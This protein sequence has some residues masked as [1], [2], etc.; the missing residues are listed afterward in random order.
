VRSRISSQIARLKKTKT[1]PETLPKTPKSR[2]VSAARCFRKLPLNEAEARAAWMN[3]WS[4]KNRVMAPFQETAL[5]AYQNSEFSLGGIFAP[6]GS[7][8]TL[9]ALAGPLIDWM[10]NPSEGLSILIISPLKSLT[11]DLVRAVEEPINELE[12]DMKVVMRTGDTTQKERRLLK[13]SPPHVLIT[14]PE[15]LSLLLTDPDLRP[16]LTKLRAVIIDEWHELYGTKRGVL[17][18]LTISFLRSLQ[19]TRL[20]TFVLSATLSDPESK[21]IDWAGLSRCPQVISEK[22]ASRPVKIKAILPRSISALPWFGFSGLKLAKEVIHQIEKSETTLLFTNTK[23][24]AERWHQELQ[25]IAPHLIPQ[26]ALHHGS[27]EREERERVEQLLKSGELRV[28]V[29]TSS[30]DLGVDFPKVDQVIQV[31]SVK[32]FSRAHQRAG[33]AFHQPGQSTELSLCPSH[34]F[35]ILEVIALRKGIQAGILEERTQLD[36]PLDVLVQFLLNSAFDRGFRPE[37]MWRLLT[38]TQ[39][40]KTLKRKDFD[41]ALTFLTSGGYSLSAYPEYRKLV[42][43]DGRYYFFHEALASDHKRNMGTI[44]SED[45]IRVQ[46][47]RGSKI[48]QLDEYFITQLN[49]GDQFYFAGQTLELVHIKDMTAYVRRAKTKRASVPV[50]SGSEFSISKALASQMKLV[51]SLLHD[52]FE[53]GESIEENSVLRLIRDRQLSVSRLPRGSEI[54]IE[55]FKS[56]EGHHLLIY[57]LEG[58]LFHQGLGHLLATRLSKI[59]ENSFAVSASDHGIELLSTEPAGAEGDIIASLTDTEGLADEINDSINLNELAK[60]SFREVARVSC[61]ISQGRPHERKSAR[62]LQ[63]SSSLLFDVF[64]KHEPDQPLLLQSFDETRRR[65]M[66]IDL[67]ETRLNEF[68]QKTFVFQDLKDLSPFA[69]P[70]LISRLSS[71]LS[72]EKL[73]TRIERMQKQAVR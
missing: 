58:K 64:L 20:K 7:G 30:L 56:T 28:V 60:R 57:T 45:G 47:Y 41:W 11:R 13:V 71:R 35:E 16:Q 44:L 66:P 32:A 22:S 36:A 52:T 5:L 40:Y 9:A 43:E 72:N 14:T 8:K 62:Q 69:F 23:S 2:E 50:W 21:L 55:R 4:A 53:I 49:P 73:E 24:Q 38:N 19:E 31:G 61:L 39:T 65:F 26:M 34:A 1:V 42:E 29:C 37:D 6:T 59:R 70:L 33:R 25:I 48:G 67:F 46:Y 51:F 18:E 17:L 54:L 63:M 15:S 27:L 12:L 68:S 10:T 3:W